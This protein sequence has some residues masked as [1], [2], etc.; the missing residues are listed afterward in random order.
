MRM[1]LFLALACAGCTANPVPRSN[2]QTQAGK[3]EMNFY[4][5]RVARNGEV[6]P[7]PILLLLSGTLAERKGCLILVN[8]AGNHALV[9]QL[10]LASF[11]MVDRRLKAGSAEIAIGESITVGGPYNQPS[12]DFDAPSIQRRCD[13]RSVWLVTG[14]QVRSLP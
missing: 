7:P 12:E 1:T 3:V 8:E 14:Q 10:G 2:D 5:R 4:E 9:F 13:V 11:N 6:L